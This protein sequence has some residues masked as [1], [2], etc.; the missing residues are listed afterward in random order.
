[1]FSFLNGEGPGN[2]SKS[3]DTINPQNNFVVTRSGKK[4]TQVL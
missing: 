2:K 1:M 3:K 4:I